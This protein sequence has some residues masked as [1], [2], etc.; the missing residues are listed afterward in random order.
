MIA[1]L[2][3]LLY[4]MHFGL[5]VLEIRIGRHAASALFVWPPHAPPTIRGLYLPVPHKMYNT[6]PQ[7]YRVHFH[8]M[9]AHRDS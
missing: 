8:S 3:N 9:I 6:Q 1:T 5:V 4:Y 7:F 2:Q